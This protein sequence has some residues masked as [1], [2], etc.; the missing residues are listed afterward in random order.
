MFSL[1]EARFSEA[2]YIFLRKAMSRCS[3]HLAE[4]QLEVHA[5]SR[6][7]VVWDEVKTDILRELQRAVTESAH[8]YYV[9]KLAGTEKQ[10]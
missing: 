8:S 5:D 7:A 4:L 6:R 1:A 10:F 2:Y 9:F 3:P